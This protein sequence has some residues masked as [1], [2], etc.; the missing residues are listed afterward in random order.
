M[1]YI[2]QNTVAAS[3]FIGTVAGHFL[4]S[5]ID[6]APQNVSDMFTSY[7]YVLAGLSQVHGDI[8]VFGTGL[9]SEQYLS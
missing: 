1:I 7:R 8:G 9:P 4:K 3:Q 2:V 5:G 6:T